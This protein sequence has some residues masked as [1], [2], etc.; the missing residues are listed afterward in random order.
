M[1]LLFFGLVWLQSQD[2]DAFDSIHDERQYAWRCF[3]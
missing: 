1:L 2:E 3:L